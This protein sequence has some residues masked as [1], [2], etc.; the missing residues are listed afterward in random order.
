MLRRLITHPPVDYVLVGITLGAA[1]MSWMVPAA[2]P[3]EVQAAGLVTGPAAPGP[4]S[5]STRLDRTSVMKGGD[6][7]VRMELVLEG[8]KLRGTIPRVPTDVIVV[9][10]KSGSMDG[11]KI[12][13]AKEA[14]AALAGM[15][16]AGDRFGVVTYDDGAR[17]LFDPASPDVAGRSSWYRSIDGIRANG[18]TNMS[19]GIDLARDRLTRMSESGRAQR[20]ILISDGLP[21]RGDATHDGLVG[22]AMSAARSEAVLTAVGVGRD[23]NE[24]LMSSIADAGTGNYYFLEQGHGL[25]SV[26]A[27]EFTT[28]SQTIASAVDVKVKLAPG[29]ELIDAGGFPIKTTGRTATFTVG[30]LFGGQERRLW[31]TFRAP[32]DGAGKT[33]IASIDLSF[34]DSDG[35][36]NAIALGDAG[37][38]ERV[39]DTTRYYSN[40]DK[41]AYEQSVLTDE[42]NYVK[43]KVSK[44]VQEGRKDDA[45]RELQEYR[46]RVGSANAVVGSAALSD[47]LTEAEELEAEV[48]DAF[49]GADSY[50]KRNSLSKKES[51]AAWK[52][53]K[54]SVKK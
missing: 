23:F 17:F 25:A 19:G 48:D 46:S 24:H 35:K 22:R 47:N 20:I 31:L 14:T 27:E 3:T 53:R 39:E 26:F 11:D 12:R 44:A 1:L 37:Q 32:T 38:V 13:F 50:D 28:A 49:E 4:V 51:A 54:T 8:Q 45:K 21:N 40:L 7:V 30:S 9:M 2:A 18:S 33:G 5:A 52:A 41:D 6:G 43:Q 42:Y 15:I 34:N 29:V 16:E 10:D 36:A